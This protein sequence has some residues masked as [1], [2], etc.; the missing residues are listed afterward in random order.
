LEGEDSAEVELPPP[1][2]EDIFDVV[3][4]VFSFSFFKKR[5]REK[6]ALKQSCSRV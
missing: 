3:V 5:E 4:V 6:R 1:N 2:M